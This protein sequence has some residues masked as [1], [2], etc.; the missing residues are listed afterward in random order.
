M[1]SPPPAEVQE[2]EEHYH[3]SGFVNSRTT[4]GGKRSFLVDFTGYGADQREW[5]AEE[6]L[7]QDLS[8]DVFDEFLKK[9]QAR[10]KPQK[11]GE[12]PARPTGK[13]SKSDARKARK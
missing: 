2:G 3:V 12:P 6:Q 5:I 4:R 7:R 8:A 11:K 10:P 13:P 9:L 1:Y